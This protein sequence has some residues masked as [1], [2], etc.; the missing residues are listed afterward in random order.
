[1][2][3]PDRNLLPSYMR[4]ATTAPPPGQDPM[5]PTIAGVLPEGSF[6]PPAPPPSTSPTMPPPGN[7]PILQGQL[8]PQGPLSAG[9]QAPPPSQMPT[10]ARQDQPTLP[11]VPSY[12]GPADRGGFVKNVLTRMLYGMGQ[13]G[14]QHVGLPTDF[15]IQRQQYSDALNAARV[16]VEQTNA[17]VAQ[18]HQQML[19]RGQEWTQQMVDIPDPLNPGATISIPRASM[20]SVLASQVRGAY[21]LAGTMY[22]HEIIPTPRGAYN[23]TTGEFL[24]E[25]AKG[26][27]VDDALIADYPQAAPA[28][29]QYVPVSTINQWY[30]QEQR[31][32]GR[33]STVSGPLG[34]KTTTTT[35]GYTPPPGR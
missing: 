21:G 19:Q 27:L 32:G 20:G 28:K 30:N 10:L 9:V 18:A 17:Q 34:Q 33:T 15:D 29:G 23:R 3:D 26:V 22:A 31:A 7:L 12:T 6:Q 24:P 8:P 11:G 14:L 35:T 16:Q 2:A 4:P 13:A 1:M 25:T 5:I